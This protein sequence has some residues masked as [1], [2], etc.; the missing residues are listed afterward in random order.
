MFRK[1]PVERGAKPQYILREIQANGYDRSVDNAWPIDL[2]EKNRGK[3][4]SVQNL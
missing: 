4:A 2:E 3:A 1:R